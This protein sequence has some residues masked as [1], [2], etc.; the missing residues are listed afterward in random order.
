MVVRNFP[1]HK[2]M[3]RVTC[4]GPSLSWEHDGGVGSRCGCL[5]GKAQFVCIDRKLRLMPSVLFVSKSTRERT[6]SHD[7][8]CC[9]CF[10]VCRALEKI[11]ITNLETD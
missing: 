2:H 6:S 9:V 11:K 5:V 7:L 4:V 8:R 1:L 3:E 10:S